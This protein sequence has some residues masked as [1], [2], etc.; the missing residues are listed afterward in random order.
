MKDLGVP[1]ERGVE[2]VSFVDSGA[3][4][5]SILRGP[6][7]REETVESQW[8][9]GCDGAHSTVRHAL[10]LPFHGETLQSDWILAD[11]HLTGMPYPDLGTGDLLARGRR[12]GDVPDLAGPLSRHRRYR[13]LRRRP[14]RRSDA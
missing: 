10:G 14:A 12:A 9:I 3:G 2:L 7:G 11:V 1:V 8:L 4:V 6:A 13:P 5:T